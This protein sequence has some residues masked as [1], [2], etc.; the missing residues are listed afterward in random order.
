MAYAG[1]RVGQQLQFLVVEMNAVRVPDVRADPAELL[2]ER[3]R[4][5]TLA[6]KHVVFLVLR[7]AQMRME[8]DVILPCKYDA[9]AQKLRRDGEW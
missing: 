1:V 7:F 9:L 5:H 6:F 8:P 2:H 4:A 3:Q